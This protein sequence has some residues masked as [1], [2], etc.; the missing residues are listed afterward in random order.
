MSIFLAMTA[1]SKALSE[2]V[3]PAIRDPYLVWIWAGPAI[4]LAGQTGI[5]WFRYREF[6]D[7]E[8]MTYEEEKSA[9][10]SERGSERTSEEEV[11]DGEKQKGRK[12]SAPQL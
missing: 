9:G 2:I 6:D 5:F 1:L 7:D 4:A 3:S 8:F 10:G 11:A 12:D